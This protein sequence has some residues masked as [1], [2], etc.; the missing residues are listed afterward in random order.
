MVPILDESSRVIGF[1]GR[2]IHS[3]CDKCQ[4][5]HGKVP[6]PSSQERNLPSFAKWRNHY[7]THRDYH[8]YNFAQARAS[9][10]KLRTVI[11]TEGPGDVWRLVEAGVDCAVALL[12]RTL[13]DSQQ[14]L[15]ESSGAF[16]VLLGLDSD[17][18]GQ[19]AIEELTGRL[20]R[21]FHVDRLQLPG[22]DLGSLSLEEIRSLLRPWKLLKE[23]SHGSVTE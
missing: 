13:S 3:L 19:Q 4:T 12:G 7:R 20:S 14:V 8:L 11:L 22:H 5:Y 1:T 17:S 6:C 21:F 9:I 16:R 2:S 15:L 10:K 23:P 18:S